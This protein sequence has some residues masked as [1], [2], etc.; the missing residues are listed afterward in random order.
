VSVLQTLRDYWLL[1]RPR[2]VALELFTILVSVVVAGQS[3]PPWLVLFHALLGNG[4]VIVGAIAMN[5]RLERTTDAQMARTACRP[6]PAGRLTVTQVT[7]FAALTSLSG[8]AYLLTQVNQAMAMLAAASW[9]IYVWIY[10]PLKPLSTLQTPIGAIVGAMPALLGA[11]VIGSPWTLTAAVLFGIVYFWQFPHSMAIA[12]LYRHQFAAADLRLATVVDPTGQLAAR[13]AVLGALVLIP[14]S[15]V[16]TMVGRLGWGYAMVVS[17][18][19]L[20]YLA[21]SFAFLRHTTNTA[22]RRLLRVSVIHLVVL[23]LALTVASMR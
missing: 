8:L 4:L 13:V 1:T 5:Q 7:S 20:I 3:V 15:L 6:L 19:G 14:I 18:L 16:P 17:I 22:A 12:W 23:L 10:T 2:I 11:A 9:A 21:A